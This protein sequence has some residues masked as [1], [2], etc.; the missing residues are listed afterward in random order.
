MSGES[1]MYTYLPVVYLGICMGILFIGSVSFTYLYLSTRE[2]L[3]LAMLLV[4]IA[5]LIF[6]GGEL[7]VLFSYLADNPPLGRQMHRIQALAAAA[8]IINLPFLVYQMMELNDVLKKTTLA[9]YWAGFALFVALAAAAF[10]E[11]SLFISQDIPMA[12]ELNIW[13]APVRGKTGPLFI[14]RDAIVAAFMLYTIFC[15]AYEVIMHRRYSYALFP[16]A[17]SVIAV[18]FVYFD[19]LHIYNPRNIMHVDSHSSF[20][21]I[22]I[23]IFIMLSMVGTLNLF[24]NRSR[25]IDRARRVESLGIFAGGV[26]HDFNNLLTVIMGNISLARLAATDPEME[27]NLVAAEKSAV[28][29]SE[30]T[31]QLLFFSKGGTPVKSVTSLG[32]LIVSTAN[33]VL[34][35]SSVKC[36]FAISPDL[37]PVAVDPGQIGQVVQN[38]IINAM[39]AMPEGGE[40]DIEADNDCTRLWSEVPGSRKKRFAHFVISDNGPGIPRRHLR[41]VFDPYFTTK[42]TGTGLGLTISYS[43]I[44]KHGGHIFVSSSRKSGTRF[45][46]YLPASTHATRAPA[47]NALE[48]PKGTGTALLMDDEPLILSVAEKMLVRMGYTVTTAKNGEEALELFRKAH[49]AGTPFTLTVLDLTVP[50]G[51]GGKESVRKMLH[52][53]PSAKVLASSGYSNDPAIE[54]FRD[55]GFSGVVEKPYRFDDFARALRGALEG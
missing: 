3:H 33:L 44:H 39:Q 54:H 6:V 31:R 49:D 37:H 47:G 13:L 22:G 34:S 17:G 4:G 27:N 50:G 18:L 25:E 51:M 46:I 52:I 45:D 7:A 8:F 36:R 48:K 40:I 1:T 43:V 14:L 24:I 35:G 20:T 16:L 28:K 38:I 55:H 32:N 30:L 23:T 15:M 41:R 11:P 12:G 2:K 10:I 42:P 26:A 53:D 9:L 29:A 21:S 5:G 19:F